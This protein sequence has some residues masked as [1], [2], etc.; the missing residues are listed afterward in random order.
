MTDYW[1]DPPEPPEVPEC[2]GDEMHVNTDGGLMCHVCD[3]VVAPIPDIE[4]FDPVVDD[5]LPDDV[6]TG[7][8]PL[9]EAILAL[10]NLPGLFDETR[11]LLK[12]AAA[13]QA[14]AEDYQDDLAFDAARERRHFGR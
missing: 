14:D 10:A 2:C 11:I 8:A 12:Q 13:R 3:R 6:P 9:S 1:N 7:Q 4:P 5:P